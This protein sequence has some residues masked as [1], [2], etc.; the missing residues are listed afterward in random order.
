MVWNDELKREIPEGWEVGSLTQF[1]SIRKE[2]VSPQDM[3]GNTVEH[4]SIP[5]FD[6][7]HYPAFDSPWTIESNKYLVKPDD[8]LYSKLNPKIKRLWDP[9]CL[10]GMP[11]CSTEF[12]VF[13]PKQADM[14]AWCLSILD[15]ESF[16]AYM[17]ARATSSTG[18]R[19]RVDPDVALAYRLPIAPKGLVP[20][21]SQNIQFVHSYFK[22]L[23]C[24]IHELS[25][26]RDW[27]L[28][29]LMNGQVKVG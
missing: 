1:L 18:S 13:V 17:A 6:E 27:L 19:S 5:S 24:E 28:P 11:V 25:T 21:Y 3:D 26:L 20:L 16:Y 14:R 8:I 7:G 4:Y 12:I 2:S 29:M 10:T 15:S 9:P 22:Q 23:N